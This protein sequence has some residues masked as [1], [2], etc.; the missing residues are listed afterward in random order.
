MSARLRR[1]ERG[2]VLVETPFAVCI[3]LMLLFGVVTIV[4]VAY[5]DLTMSSTVR[6][7]TR[8]ASHVEYLPGSGSSARRRDAQQVKEWTAEVAAEAGVETTDVEVVGY[9]EPSHT[10]VSSLDQ[11]VAGDSV[12]VTVT[13]HV[14]NS[15]YRLA[16]SVTNVAS[17]VVGAGDVFDPT[18]IG[19]SAAASTYVE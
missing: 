8:F 4:Q 12:T 9:H 7:A 2:S 13:K 16:A 17:N 14:T 15:L 19:V 1:D 11:L 6:T 3:L 5:T 10:P 18:G